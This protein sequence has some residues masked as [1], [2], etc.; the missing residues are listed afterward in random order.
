M[1][2]VATMFTPAGYQLERS[3]LR[4]ERT[5]D[6]ALVR[7]VIGHP[8]I[9]PL[10]LEGDDVPVPMHES[11]Y[12]LA[13]KEERHADGAVEDV[14]LGIVAFMPINNVSWNP[15]IAIL[16][17]HRGRGTE[18][19]KAALAWMF[20]NTACEK[21]VAHPPAYNSKMIKVFEKCGFRLEGCS[22]KSFRWNGIMHARLLYGLEKE[23]V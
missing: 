7:S 19:M 13:P 14:L 16:P 5:R 2:S 17:E 4:I 10:V 22:P 11:I 23:N 3:Q 21:V 18:V 1:F 12:Y 6:A 9:R 15:H 20:E 8:E